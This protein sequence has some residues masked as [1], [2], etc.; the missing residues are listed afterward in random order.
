[1]VIRM[2]LGFGRVTLK[3]RRW[4]LHWE[5]LMLREIGWVKQTDLLRVMLMERLMRWG[6]VMEKR[7]D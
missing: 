1:M 6:F 2:R 5:K 4:D 7:W 3:A